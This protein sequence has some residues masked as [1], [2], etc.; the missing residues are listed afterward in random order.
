MLKQL[1]L[2]STI[3]ALALATIAI[4]PAMGAPIGAEDD[5]GK[6]FWTERMMKAMDKNK[7]GMVSREEY[8]NYMGAQFD[9]MDVKK[10]KMLTKT[11]FMDSK[12]R[13]A[14]F[15]LAGEN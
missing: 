2:A 14:T 11:E 12:M 15:P 3:G 1:K 6:M 7:D 9:K 8:M 10:K 5:L 13:A 4:S